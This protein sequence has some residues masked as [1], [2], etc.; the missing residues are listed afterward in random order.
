[1]EPTPPEL[2]APLLAE[3]TVGDTGDWIATFTVGHAM[4]VM[5]CGLGSSRFTSGFILL[6]VFNLG[7]LFT[8]TI[9]TFDWC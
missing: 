1:M 2:E 7:I 3:D 4:S 9:F 6:R 5:G 8:L